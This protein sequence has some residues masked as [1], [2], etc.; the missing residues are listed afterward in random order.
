MTNTRAAAIALLPAVL[1]ALAAPLAAAPAYLDSFD[2]D[3]V[4]P[5]VWTFRDPV[6]DAS[7]SVEGSRARIALPAGVSHDL[8]TGRLLAPRLLA[9]V[10]DA[11]FTIEVKFDSAVT[12]RF[13]TQ[14]IIAQQ[15]ERN[16]VR[17][18]IYHDGAGVR[19][20]AAVFVD[21][22]AASRLY[23][24][25]TV[26]APAFLRVARVADLWTFSYSGDGTTWTTVGTFAHGIRV[27]SLGPFAGNHNDPAAATPAH[28]VEIDY[29]LTDAIS[30]PQDQTPPVISALSIDAGRTTATVTWTTD[31]PATSIVAYGPTSE[32]DGGTVSDGTLTTTHLVTLSGLAC[33][34]AYH[35]RVASADVA[36]NEA[37][38]DDRTFTTDACPVAGD[39]PAIEIWYGDAQRIGALGVPQ[40]WVNILGNVSDPDGVASLGYSLNGG[41]E[42]P[43]SRGPDARRLLA[44]GDFNVEIDAADLR[45]GANTVAVRAA[46]ALGNET[47]REVEVTFTAAT[48]WP[49]PYAIDWTA[50]PDIGS[51]AQVVDGRW[52]IGAQGVRTVEWGYDRL[53]ALGDIAWTDYTVTVPITIHAVQPGPYGFPGSVPGVGLALRWTGHTENP[54]HVDGMQPRI[55]YWPLGSL[56]W[57]RYYV[58]GSGALVPRLTLSD[59]HGDPSAMDATGFRLFEGHTY[60]FRA[61]VRTEAQGPRYT[62]TVWEQGQPEDS[63]ATIQT[64]DAS[65]D[66]PDAGGILFVAH[67][68]DASFGDASVEP[69]GTPAAPPAISHIAVATTETSAT[70]SWTTADP[71]TSAVAYGGTAAYEAGTVEDP[72]LVTAHRIVLEGL[73]CASAYHF[74]VSSVD[75]GGDTAESA[76]LEFATRPCVDARPPIISGV[77]VTATQTTAT[78]A[79]TTNEPALGAVLW[80]PTPEV[81]AG[82]VAGETLA[83]IHSLTIE[84]LSCG[85]TYY[86]QVSCADETGNEAAGEVIA[87]DTLPCPTG[88]A[89]IVSDEFSGMTLDASLWTLIDPVGDVGIALTGTHLEIALPGG[90]SHDLW[91]GRLR[92]PRLLQVARDEDFEIEIKYDSPVSAQ[93]QMQGLVVQE[94]DANLLRFEVYGDGA[95]EHAFAASFSDGVA[96]SRGNVVV[97]IGSPMYL[98]LS[99]VGDLW[100]FRTSPDGST[101]ATALAF[102]HA[103]RVARV[104]PYI[105]N[106]ASPESATPAHTASIDHF[107]NVAAPAQDTTAP[108]IFAIQVTAGETSATVAW[109]TDEPATGLVAYGTTTAYE[110]GSVSSSSL[111]TSHLLTIDGLACGTVHHLRIASADEA[112]NLAQSADL[113]IETAAC[114]DLSPPAIADVFVSTTETTATV[115]WMTDE[116][117]TSHVAYGETSDHGDGWV[118]EPALVTSHL[119]T[120]DGLSCGSTYHLQVSSADEAGNAA[121][122]EDLAF[123][124]KACPAGAG[125]VTDDFSEGGLDP[126]VWTVDDP[127]GDAVISF[128]DR[129]LEIALPAGVSHDLWT[130]RLNATRILQN[131]RDEDL[132]VEVKFDTPV[133]RRY[134]LQG[135]VVEEDDANLLRFDIYHDGATER[136][137]A[138]I[139]VDGIASARANVPVI[140]GA[141]MFLLVTRVGD[142]WTFRYSADGASWT[143][144]ASFTHAI[145]VTRVGPFAGNHGIPA[146]ASPAH[147]VSI[148]T[149]RNTM[150]LP[151]PDATPPA[152]GGVAV[153]ATRT[154]ATVTW[155]TDEPATSRAAYGR[156]EGYE[157]GAVS[158]DALLMNHSIRLEGLACGTIYHVRVSSADA[159]GNIATGM[160]VAFSTED[161]PAPEAAGIVSDEFDGPALDGDL[162]TLVDP[163]GDAGATATGTHLE[164]ALPG[165]ISHDLWTGRLNATRILQP[166]RDEDFEIEVKYDTPV[167]RR[168]QM[169][170]LVIE[171]DAL[172]LIRVEIFH[173]GTA[174]RAFAA[175]FEDGIATARGNQAISIGAPMFLR[176]ARAGST[177]TLRASSDGTTWTTAL[178]FAHAIHVA[179][180]G[181]YIGNQATPESATPA[182]TASIDYFRNVS[183]PIDPGADTT[184]PV[185]SGILVA[186]TETAAEVEWTTNEAATSRVAYGATAA[187]ETG[188]IDDPALGTSHRVTI[189]GLA[190]GTAYHLRI[191][192]ADAAGNA[193]SSADLTFTTQACAASGAG[194]VSDDFSAGGLD[195]RVWTLVDTVGDAGAMLTGTHLELSVP[196]GASHDLW[197]GRLRAPRILQA[198]R[199]EDLDVIVTYDSPVAHRYQMQGLVVEQDALNLVR[200]DIFHDGT[201]ARAFAATIAGGVATARVNLPIAIGA[202]MHLR[203]SRTGNDWRCQ[204]SSD[205]AAWTTIAAFSHTLRVTYVGPFIGNHG[206]PDT[207]SPAHVAAID[208]FVNTAAPLA[209]ED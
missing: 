65:A 190:C 138:A 170:G 34:S 200:F 72:S 134:Q 157:A 1:L 7:L 198:A 54:P 183:T 82:A 106:Q 30:S 99:R 108:V 202:R 20:F 69:I 188:A 61:S 27:A 105:A 133:T 102:T 36:G 84:S 152:I 38:G 89:G 25:A 195:S 209:A 145:R 66:G 163:I 144:A 155:L 40:R 160:D 9:D 130:G 126:Q 95:A 4:D 154:E 22:L 193:A 166:A 96:T 121:A 49:L 17:F 28:T 176:L 204:I 124:T 88:G 19:A 12:Q 15:D 120:I 6:G 57:Y 207:A 77:T 48:V 203:I 79:W 73:A 83:T 172:D 125:I 158:D 21:G 16:L 171:Q 159:A 189:G 71:R 149:F 178:V 92:A 33:Q 115:T 64:L 24:P 180:V 206:V 80:G 35:L 97:S 201:T 8:W 51:V 58:D 146:A 192:S 186:A 111:E 119:L 143:T 116:P 142:L 23:A 44:A 45:V 62:L 199:D 63:G 156:T 86:V 13:Q 101:W 148:D 10:T 104:G 122:G 109:T 18:D 208:S 153:T 98:R 185:I 135:I 194:I 59:S 191:T 131:A 29:V 94:D 128:T 42:L 175:T 11:D 179:R 53:V 93:Y 47:I 140:I 177:W 173:D 14:G 187:Y 55:G 205:G 37:I 150:A 164:I 123:S 43:L 197:T 168:Y 78:V 169:Q 50:T 56:A 117:A 41:A 2:G 167:T 162:W 100:T 129:S 112:G 147:T 107:R 141:P 74:R 39:G 70:V 75:G 110:G 90:V 137:F 46:D 76:D 32:L 85:A 81:D 67:L 31:E 68:L 5:A 139:V 113:G 3:A 151:P 161:C 91:T 87:F 60:V 26:S 181:P 52:R 118:S 136:A 127:L 196:G 182:H 184:T 165:G 114:P 103:M 132:E 174:T